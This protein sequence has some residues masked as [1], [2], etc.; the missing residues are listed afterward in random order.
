MHF[1]T[2]MVAPLVIPLGIPS[3]FS[4]PELGGNTKLS[5]LMFASQDLKQ[6][7]PQESFYCSPDYA[8]YVSSKQGEEPGAKRRLINLS[9]A[10][11][12]IYRITMVRRGANLVLRRAPI[13]VI[14]PKL[15]QVLP[16]RS[17]ALRC[18]CW[19]IFG[20]VVKRQ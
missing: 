7:S 11:L 1:F 14:C 6:A 10:G 19:K 5:T 16:K 2:E 15:S 20:Q 12:C 3:R 9:Y 17:Q 4:A 13:K 8:I 18:V